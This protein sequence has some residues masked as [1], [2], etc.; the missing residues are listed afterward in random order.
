MED[1]QIFQNTATAANSI[2]A[3]HGVRANSTAVSL[4]TAVGTETATNRYYPTTRD[5]YLWE[6]ST[7][8]TSNGFPSGQATAT[9][10][11][12]IYTSRLFPQKYW[13][14]FG[15]TCD[16]S[17][18]LCNQDSMVVRMNG[19]RSTSTWNA[20]RMP[21][22]ARSNIFASTDAWTAPLQTRTGPDGALWVLDW[23][24]Y[25]F[26]HNP[27]S[28]NGAG[29][30]W[31]NPVARVKTRNRIYRIVPTSGQLEPVLNLT[32]ASITTLVVTLHNPNMMWRLHAQRLL[33]GRTYNVQ[34]KADLLNALEGILNR[35]WSDAVE[36]DAPVIHALWTLHGLGEFKNNPTRWDPKLKALLLHPAWTV[37]RNVLRA[38]PRTAASAQAIKDQGRVNDPHGHVRL[39]AFIAISEIDSTL[40]APGFRGSIKLFA[41]FRTVDSL[42]G[43]HA[44]TMATA[45]GLTD[46]ADLPAIPALNAVVGIKAAREWNLGA[47]ARRDLRYDV[48]ANGFDLLPSAKLDNGELVVTDLRGH[49]VFRSTY[50]AAL[51]LWS[52]RSAR[53]LTHQVYFY[54]FREARGTSFSGRIAMAPV[55]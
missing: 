45:A 1:G 6:G 16:G 22:Q 3:Q 12:Q 15:F 13:N 32:N 31:D 18:H 19:T 44:S 5:S 43:N 53:N 54:T 52:Q 50:S 11:Y 23:Y 46:T 49:T 17:Y 41:G 20:M 2:T 39:Q 42:S 7:S 21:G 51:G 47:Q 34:E 37:R 10:S 8:E 55:Y 33:L 30:A 24:N 27:A 28:P 9:N 38:M 40:L 26:L 35:R 36:L 14:R 48:R 25:L 4:P 29:Q